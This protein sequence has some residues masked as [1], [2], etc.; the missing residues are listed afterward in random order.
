MKFAVLGAGGVGGYFGGRLAAAGQ[1]VT[2]LARGAHKAAIE[3]NG[4]R[5]LSELGD[6]TVET[7]AVSDDI[8]LVSEADV[9]LVCV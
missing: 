8:A 3:R 7:L 9:V 1:E 5:I 4:L 6:E 2:L